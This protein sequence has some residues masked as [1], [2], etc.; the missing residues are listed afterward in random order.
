MDLPALMA[1][2]RRDELSARRALESLLRWESDDPLALAAAMPDVELSLPDTA[3]RRLIQRMGELG[4]CIGGAV[5]GRAGDCSALLAV[6]LRWYR[7]AQQLGDDPAWAN[8]AADAFA[9][10]VNGASA[11]TADADAI[12]HAQTLHSVL[13][14]DSGVAMQPPP[15]TAAQAQMRR[16]VGVKVTRLRDKLRDE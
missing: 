10:A 2:L 12:A 11:A 13:H 8:V 6:A 5:V 16:R 1:D 9:R 4:V 3:T 15:E 14:R 7:D